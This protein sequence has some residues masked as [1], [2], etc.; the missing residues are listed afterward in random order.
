MSRGAITVRVLFWDMS[1]APPAPRGHGTQQRL[2]TFSCVRFCWKT[3]LDKSETR[4]RD[5]LVRMNHRGGLS[6]RPKL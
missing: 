4:C 2:G 5:V 1:P 6:L 3:L